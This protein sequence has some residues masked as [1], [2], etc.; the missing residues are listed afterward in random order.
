MPKRIGRETRDRNNCTLFPRPIRSTAHVHRQVLIDASQRSGKALSLGKGTLIAGS[1]NGLGRG[2]GVH[3]R[4]LTDGSGFNAGTGT[5][6]D[7]VALKRNSFSSNRSTTPSG[8][9]RTNGP[10]STAWFWVFSSINIAASSVSI[11][12]AFLYGFRQIFFS[13]GK[14]QDIQGFFPGLDPPVWVDP[15]LALHNR[16][17]HSFTELFSIGVGLFLGPA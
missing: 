16:V 9:S 13:N 4:G 14:P 12:L 11:A 6:R 15:A 5:N 8:R 10:R 2:T 1:S 3:L 17:G 7:P